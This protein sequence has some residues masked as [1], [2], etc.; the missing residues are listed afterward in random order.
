MMVG[1]TDLEEQFGYRDANLD[2][3]ITLQKPP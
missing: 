1:F 3:G 2:I